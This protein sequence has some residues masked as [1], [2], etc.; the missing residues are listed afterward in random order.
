MTDHPLQPSSRSGCLSIVAFVLAV[1]SV[2]FGIVAVAELSGGPRGWTVHALER[3][4]YPARP[5]PYTLLLTGKG[6][7]G[8]GAA[9][10]LAT[11][12]PVTE[13]SEYQQRPLPD[14]TLETVPLRSGLRFIAVGEHAPRTFWDIFH[15]VDPD[16][17]DPAID[18][19]LSP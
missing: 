11:L 10:R 5:E 13:L 3:E 15:T 7:S 8:E 2:V 18:D 17:T 1:A 12:G 16:L 6:N 9:L 14:G 19:M 4:L